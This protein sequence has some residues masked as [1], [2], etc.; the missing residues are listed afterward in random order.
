MIIDALIYGDTPSA[1]NEAFARAPPEIEFIRDKNVT[2]P[3]IE[4]AAWL[5]T[6]GSIPGTVSQHPTRYTN[7]SN[8]V[9]IIFFLRSLTLKAFMNVLNIF[10][11]PQLFHRLF[12]FFL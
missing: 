11:S 10:K 5:K 7:K 8:N 12:L 3:S 9:I 6:S 2:P 4:P 1:R